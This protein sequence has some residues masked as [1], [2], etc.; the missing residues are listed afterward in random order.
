MN[1]RFL[2]STV[3]I[4]ASAITIPTVV[5]AQTAIRELEQRARGT[6]ISGTVTNVV[7]NNFTLE[8]RTGQ[9]IVDAGPRWWREI[10]LKRGEQVTVVGEI[11]KG[12]EFDAFSIVRSNGSKIEIRPAEGPPPWAGN[13]TKRRQ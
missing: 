4:V 5:Q 6:T 7:G 10:N 12:S 1:R 11:D 8:D 2:S 13:A 9:I 3:A